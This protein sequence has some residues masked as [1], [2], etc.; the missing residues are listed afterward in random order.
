MTKDVSEVEKVT[1]VERKVSFPNLQNQI[2][3]GAVSKIIW[4]DA[5]ELCWEMLKPV[6]LDGSRRRG[7]EGARTSSGRIG[8]SRSGKK[9]GVLIE[10]R[11]VWGEKIGYR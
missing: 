7:G 9:K 2:K 10:L 5:D 11:F 3:R 6:D 1:S 8:V 4:C